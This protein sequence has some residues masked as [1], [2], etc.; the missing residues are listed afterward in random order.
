MSPSVLRRQIGQLVGLGLPGYTVPAEWK[1]LA[2]EF[3][4]GAVV[5]FGRNVSEPAQVAELAFDCASLSSDPPPWVAVDQEGGRVARLRAP[6]T[7]WP[8]AVTLGRAGD[9]AVTRRVAT[10]MAKELRSLGITFD[11]APVLDVLTTANNPAIG[12]RAIASN[13]ATVSTLGV[14]FITAMQEAGVAACGK[15]F[16]GHGDTM[17]DSHHDLPL[18]EHSPE[19]L[20]AVEY[21]PFRAA[22]TAGVAGIMVA[23]L[24]V[25]AFDE[26][27]PASL[28]RR[29]VTD[30]LRIG[31]HFD[32][33]IVTDDLYMK[34]C[35][36]RTPVPEA[37]VQAALAGHDLLLLC[38][39][40]VDD[41]AAALEAL[42]HA[43]EEERLPYAQVER[44]IA[45]HRRLK[46]RYLAGVADQ[47]RPSTAWRDVIGCEAHQLVAAE[48]RQYV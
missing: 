13:V 16:P 32:D 41:H 29:V 19:R 33:L 34:G 24:L 37:A 27:R 5:L 42:V 44:S 40:H 25:P 20:R 38:E 3:G 36:A 46:A 7:V 10:A 9:E 39:P 48:L 30:E 2:R 21:E 15:H 45:R 12:D 26:Q 1:S 14:A 31:L 47:R 11:F 17:V 8:P 43:V 22:V 6:L 35:S 4:I 18:V 23:H 28:S